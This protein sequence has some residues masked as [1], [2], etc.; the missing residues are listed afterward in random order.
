MCQDAVFLCDGQVYQLVVGGRLDKIQPVLKLGVQAPAE[1][2]HLLLLCVSMLPS[3]LT[4]AIEKLGVLEHRASSLR[5]Q[6]E[7]AQLPVQEAVWYVMGAEGSLELGL[8]EHVVGRKH[9]D[10]IVPPEPRS[11]SQLLGCESGLV[12]VGARRCEQRVWIR[13]RGSKHPHRVAPPFG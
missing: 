9:D 5:E 13:L 7:L 8:G 6:Q 10:M 11:T 1:S 12:R 4:Q 2:V 3:I